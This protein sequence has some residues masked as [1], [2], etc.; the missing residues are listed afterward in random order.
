MVGIA[1]GFDDGV[2]V[3]LR[4]SRWL[5]RFP[6]SV[7]GGST[8]TGTAFIGISSSVMASIGLLFLVRR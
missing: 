8:C 1:V 2:L 6:R 5:A 7:V 4:A 3:S